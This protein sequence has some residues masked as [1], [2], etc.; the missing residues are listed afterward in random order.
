MGFHIARLGV[1]GSG[2]A[3]KGSVQRVTFGPIGTHRLH[4]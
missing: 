4:A 3:R 2:G 1:R